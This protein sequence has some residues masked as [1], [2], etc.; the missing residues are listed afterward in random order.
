M[1][2]Q[3]RKEKKEEKRK[4]VSKKRKELRLTVYLYIS[5]FPF[6]ELL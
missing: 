6:L 2:D 3:G 4:Q 1:I 5:G